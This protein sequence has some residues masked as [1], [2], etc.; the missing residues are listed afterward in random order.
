MFSSFDNHTE[1]ERVREDEGDGCGEDTT[2][3]RCTSI[4]QGVQGLPLAFTF[5]LHN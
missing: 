1:L 3:W 5:P 4:I 2:L